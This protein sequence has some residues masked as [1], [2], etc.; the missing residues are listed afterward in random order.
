MTAA[1][2]LLILSPAELPQAP[3]TALAQA[4]A[5]SRALDQAPPVIKKKAAP[6]VAAGPTF[7]PTHNCPSCGKYVTLVQSGRANVPGHTHR[8]PRCG[9]DWW[10]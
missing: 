3:P 8:C 4:P 6:A 1:L 2:L 10:H 9:T 5:V 7:H